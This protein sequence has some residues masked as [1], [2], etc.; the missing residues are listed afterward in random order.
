MRQILATLSI[1]LA[2]TLTLGLSSPALAGGPAELPGTIALCGGDKDDGDKD[3]D[4]AAA[5]Q[6]APV[7]SLCG[8]D[9][10]DDDKG[11]GTAAITGS[12]QPTALGGDGKDCGCSDG[13]GDKK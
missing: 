11:G 2:A 4:A 3:G 10:D 13:D 9:K 5:F 12:P 6:P 7:I 8:G 1:A